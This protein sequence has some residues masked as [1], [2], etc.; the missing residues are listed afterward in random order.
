M[1]LYYNRQVKSAQQIFWS[2]LMLLVLV[3]GCKNETT[4]E[5][6]EAYLADMETWKQKRDKNLRSETGF[7]NLAGLFWLEEGETTFGS[8][9]TNTFQF[10][11]GSPEKI[12]TFTLK[13]NVVTLQTE[14]GV[15]VI[16]DSMVA[17]N[18][19]K[20]FDLNEGSGKVMEWNQFRWFVIERSGNLGIRLRDL[21]H[22]LTK[23][24][25]NLDYY[26]VDND[27]NVEATF[28]PFETS[29]KV[30]ID[31]I[32]GFT[33]EEEYEGKLQFEI[34]G[35]TYSLLP[36]MGD[37]SMFIMFSDATSGRETYGGG[38]Y[39]TTGIPVENKVIID[40]NKAF[41]PPC[42]FTDYATCPLPPKEND[43]PFKLEA[44]EKTFH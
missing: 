3:S 24:P 39:L 14:E 12:G 42:A 5:L 27:W 19:T 13:D 21:D 11:Q 10:P 37:E 44:G 31:N 30:M 15:D 40:F 35:K 16:I 6:S 8:D 33:F 43:L 25:I 38:R 29:K 23:E 34:E 17:E 26:P 9:S 18:Q 7:V 20:V 4:S 32:V 22:P 41:N 1:I 28:V 2:L 36:S